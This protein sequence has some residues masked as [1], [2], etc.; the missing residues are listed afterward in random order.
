MVEAC[1]LNPLASEEEDR[2]RSRLDMVDIN[3]HSQDLEPGYNHSRRVIQDSSNKCSRNRC[4]LAMQ[5]NSN[6][7]KSSLSPQASK[8]VNLSLYHRSTPAT[9]DKL[10]RRLGSLRFN[11]LSRPL[12]PRLLHVS[13]LSR[14]V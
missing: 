14:Q 10:P 6:R 1:S 3:N 5:D 2:S 12:L 7:H 9:L 4:I 8:V 11:N 13:S